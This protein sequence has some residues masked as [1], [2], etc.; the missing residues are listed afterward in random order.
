MGGVAT[1]ALAA[2][3]LPLT[4]THAQS[5]PN[6]PAQ[7][8]RL[9]SSAGVPFTL[10]I[11]TRP[12]SATLP[13]TV[14]L[15]APVTTTATQQIT[16]TTGYVVQPGD[17]LFVIAQ[18]LGV[19]MQ[20]LAEANNLADIN[21]I[22]VGQVLRLPGSAAPPALSQPI[23][24]L[25]APPVDSAALTAR[26]TP[27]AQ[28]A[29]P[30]SPFH[31]TTWVTFYGRPGIPIMGILG[32]DAPLTVTTQLRAQ[33]AAY[34]AANG[35]DLDVTP[36]FH[37]VYGM[38]TKAP[39]DDGRH[40]SYL[41]DAVV[42]QYIDVALDEGL[43]VILDVQIGGHSPAES[44]QPALPFLRH[45]NVHLA[46][47]PEFAMTQPGQAW[48]GN[49]IGYVTAAQ[50]NAVQQVM[51]EYLREE[52]LPGPRVLLVHQFQ[53]TMIVDKDQL[54]SSVPEVALAL[55][56]DG[57]G[58]PYAKIT[59]YNALVDGST[60]FA[61]FK[62]FYDYDEPLL[63][64]AQALGTEPGLAGYTIGVTPNLIIYQ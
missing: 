27:A 29:P 6:E 40:V 28:Q 15:A 39:G 35:A 38:A 9:Q 31:R 30:G 7:T 55:S 14:L 32:A 19:D 4:T 57:F 33:A 58:S 36:A 64:E 17:T 25:P 45:P 8:V 34:D 60:P 13:L 5:E 23:S 59:K 51:A 37:L 10:T 41:P 61:A 52:G 46:I 53:N 47:D 20:T 24:P 3:L 49:P 44:I 22:E 56:V 12:V 18:Q 21:V 1:I 11:P 43:A 63:T 2:L 16:R 42:Q 54:D 62:L 50:V 26:L 48:P